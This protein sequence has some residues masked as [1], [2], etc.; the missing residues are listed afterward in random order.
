MGGAR[1]G[2]NIL[3]TDFISPIVAVG[4]PITITNVDT[5]KPHCFAGV[6]F[7]TDSS[8][9]TQAIPGAGTVVI[10]IKTFNTD[11]VFEP[12]PAGTITGAAP[13][14]ISWAANTLDVKATPS[15]ITVATHYRLI[16]TCNET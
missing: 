14:T 11:P 2:P 3:M 8:G 10:T 16:V 15:G 7:F 4:T 1:R 12:T 9:S 13:V 6:Q 5:V